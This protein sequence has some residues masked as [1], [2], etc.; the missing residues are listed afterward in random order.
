MPTESILSASFHH[1]DAAVTTGGLGQRAHR[2]AHE[3]AA[4][5]AACFHTVAP[6][7]WTYVG[8]GLSNQ[9]FVQGPQGVIAIDTG[10]SVQEMGDALARLREHTDAPVVAV[11][12][13]HFHYVAG[14]R[15]IP[16]AQALPIWSHARVDANRHRTGGEIAPMYQRGLV[17][18]FGIRLP[19]DGE[20]GLVSV[21]LGPWFRNPAHAPFTTGYLPPTNTFTEPTE[22]TLAG[23]PVVFTPAPSDADDSVTVWFPTLGLAVNNLVW[24]ALFNVFAIRG[25]EYRD[26]RVLLTG[27]DHLNALGAQHLVGAHGPPLSGAQAIREVVTDYRDAIQF[28]WDQTVRGLNRGLSADE[29]TAFVQ[30]PA[31]FQ[32]TYFTQQHYGLAEHHV[33]QIQNG[34]IGWFDGVESSLFPLPPVERASRLIAGFGGR[35]AVRQQSAQALA[36][37]DL[38]WALE[39]A[40]WLVRSQSGP[41]GRADGGT[42]QERASLAAVLRAIAQRSTAANIRNWCLTRA[43]ELEGRIDLS[44][45]RTHGFRPAE[46]EARP[47]AALHTL[48]VLL[49]PPR[50]AALDHE[51]RLVFDDGSSA[52]LRLRG[53]VA[54]PTD[55]AAAD[56][57]L[58]LSAATWGRILGGRSRLDQAHDAGEITLQQGDWALARRLLACFDHPSFAD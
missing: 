56:V 29:L 18:Q 2:M 22:T 6:G 1:D 8:N 34:L 51:L 33:R 3:Q 23:L 24:P 54:V 20:D 31:R 43:L 28:L 14:T 53:G 21:G 48:R 16:G 9:T 35:D 19:A 41:A 58:A 38:R 46:V 55:G 10:E 52:G 49:D 36:D 25:E 26:P 45:Q 11:I 32:R 39:L 47:A 15:A 40:T 50:A 7:V 13:T 30:L 37:G 17:H 27:L 57:T 12:Y 44:R 42:P 4:R 5:V